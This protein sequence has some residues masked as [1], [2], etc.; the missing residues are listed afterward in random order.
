MSKTE[1]RI[2]RLYSLILDARRAE[3]VALLDEALR[4]EGFDSIVSNYLEP[5][6][7]TIGERWSHDSVSLAQAYVA[8]KVAEDMLLRFEAGEPSA[9][10]RP[11]R[12]VAVLGNAEDDYHGLGRRMVGTFLRLSGWSVSDLGNDVLPGL[13]VD[14]A[15][16]TGASV[17]GVSAM[18]LTNARNIVAVREELDKRGLAGRIGLAVGGAV[19]ALRPGLVREVGGDGTAASAVEAP[20]LFDKLAAERSPVLATEDS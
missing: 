8:G 3:A 9:S 6:L 17:I 14:E 20:A 19:F 18:M 5:V 11:I 10:A 1:E 7:R 13:F 2:A 16:R 4:A 12:G 15:L